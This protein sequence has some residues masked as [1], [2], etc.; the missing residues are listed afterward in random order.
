MAYGLIPNH[1]ELSQAVLIFERVTDSVQTEHLDWGF[2]FTNVYGT[3]T[4]LRR[5]KATSANNC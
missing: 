1:I 5:P 3:I 4:V 2:K